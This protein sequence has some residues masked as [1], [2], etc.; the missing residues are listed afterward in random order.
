MTWG[1][2]PVSE[3]AP[4]G[5]RRGEDG[6]AWVWQ[7]QMR[8]QPP[9]RVEVRLTQT[10][11]DWA[12]HPSLAPDL[13]EAVLTRGHS[14]I[15]LIALWETPPTRIEVDTAGRWRLGGNVGAP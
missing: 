6:E 11:I 12:N 8:D 15:A 4:G 10:L 9:R 5:A 3:P 14:E 1:W 13:R 7:V 2:K